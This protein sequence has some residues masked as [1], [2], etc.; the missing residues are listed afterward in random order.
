M[1]TTTEELKINITVNAEEAEQKLEALRSKIT[2]IAALSEKGNFQHLGDLAKSIKTM[3]GSADKLS[4]VAQNLKDIT[5][6]ASAFSKSLSGI[7]DSKDAFA[8][9]SKSLKS[10]K[11]AL[12]DAETVSSKG[13]GLFSNLG[14][15]SIGDVAGSIVSD[16]KRIGTAGAKLAQLPFKMLFSPIQGLA[17][18][19]SGLASGFGHLFHMIGRVAFMR[20]LRGAIRMVT[21]AIK[22]GVTAV[23]DWASAVGNGFASTMNSITTSLTYFR[24]SIGAAISPILDAVAPVLDAVIDKCVAVINVFNQLIA[25]LTGASTWRRAE[26]VAT[27]FGGATNNAAKGANNA[28][29]A[30][31]ELK[32]T[33]LGFDE[34]NRLDAPDKGSGS[35]GSGGGGGGGASGAGA[36]TFTNQPISDAVENFADMLREAWDKGDFTEVGNTIGEKIGGALL[37][38]PWETKIQPTVVKLATSFGTL[39][40]GMFSYTGSGG[41]KMWDGIAYTAYNAL[42]TA[43]LGYVT[44]FNTVN[45]NG[46]GQGIGAALKKVLTDG[47]NWDLVAQSLSA[48]PNAVIDAIDG[49]CR[50]F[51]MS[52]FTNAGRNIGGAVADALIN[53]KWD[54]LFSDGVKMAQGILRAING[55]LESFGERWGEIKTGIVNGI[56]K[57]PAARWEDIGYQIGRL[58]VNAAKFIANIV[59]TVVQALEEA[60]WGSIIDGIGRGISENVDWSK[61]PAKV[62]GWIEDHLGTI[63]IILGLVI[64]KTA[65]KTTASLLRH[66]VMTSTVG[67]SG[68]LNLLQWA[69]GLTCVASLAFAVSKL[70]AT[71]DKE[72]IDSDAFKQQLGSGIAGAIVGLAFFGLSGTGLGFLIGVTLN[73]N[74]KKVLS[75]V[76]EEVAKVKDDMMRKLPGWFK[77]LMGWDT[78]TKKSTPSELWGQATGI[79]APNSTTKI[80]E[81]PLEKIKKTAG[82]IFTNVMESWS[83]LSL[84][85]NVYA[86]EKPKVSSKPKAFTP[87]QLYDAPI[88]PVKPAA[89]PKPTT[90]KPQVPKATPTLKKDTSFAD[91]GFKTFDVGV[92]ITKATDKLSEKQK[93]LGNGSLTL[94]NANDNI[95]NKNTFNWTAIYDY[96]KGK[97]VTGTTISNFI[98]EYINRTS[99][100]NALNGTTISNFIAEFIK[101]QA[102]KGV[103]VFSGS[104]I[105]NFVAEFIRRQAKK[106][107]NVFGA[108]TI[109]GFIAQIVER[110]VKWK[111]PLDQFINFIAK[112]TSKKDSNGH[113]AT[114]GIYKNGRWQPVQ[115]YA[116]GGLIGTTGQMFI[117][118]E[119][120]PEL[121]GTIGGDTAIMNNDQ[122][123]SSVSAG[124]ARAVAGVL[125]GQGDA[126]IEVIVK[127]DSE[128]LYRATKKGE[129]K[130]NGRYGTVVAIG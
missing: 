97:G 18:R 67:G 105:S 34:I 85:G 115:R 39:L 8:G 75:N 64:G 98:A 101:R 1:A 122:I 96:F 84:G 70:K 6:H 78:D 56:K 77:N 110:V 65:L 72:G 112:I 11:A 46:I 28:N 68:G 21:Q 124:V 109:S 117:A 130:A 94:Q 30:A 42:N 33:L 10:A 24:N 50:Q 60:D 37:N 86:A 126:P 99:K 87:K 125:G 5:D 19:V 73:L 111:N 91:P 48:F 88:G 82:N 76:A 92:N 116:S 119:A 27:S 83:T 12:E 2:K 129:R 62:G 106:G 3:A 25:T 41:K 108:S 59:D 54:T 120:G 103:N 90:P 45:W 89:T 43:M 44:F 61:A 35:G 114:G 16:F 104:T 36:L 128:V 95:K 66:M 15:M 14:T 57:I 80:I 20:A 32:R 121:V 74:V 113:G 93:T 69:K 71:V 38:V 26:K 55:A 107:V 49:F 4:T 63:S 29:K 79:S 100:N 52:D 23:Y 13:K 127:L 22:E 9:M 53:I 51:K 81:S 102:K 118:R 123:V 58:L 40:K 47:I 17:T 31:K 7:K